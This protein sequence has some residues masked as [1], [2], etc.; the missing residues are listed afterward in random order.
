MTK[1]IGMLSMYMAIIV[2][3]CRS[4]STQANKNNDTREFKLAHHMVDLAGLDESMNYFDF[5]AEK[6]DVDKT[7]EA[8]LDFALPTQMAYFDLDQYDQHYQEEV[9]SADVY[10]EEAKHEPKTKDSYLGEMKVDVG[11]L[12]DYAYYYWLLKSEYFIPVGERCAIPKLNRDENEKVEQEFGQLFLAK[13]PNISSERVAIILRHLNQFNLG[14]KPKRRILS[15][16]MSLNR[17]NVCN[18]AQL[19]RLVKQLHANKHDTNIGKYLGYLSYN[20]SRDCRQ[21][22]LELLGRALRHFD[23]F[24]K[25][26]RVLMRNV[27][28]VLRTYKGV[29]FNQTPILMIVEQVMVSVL[30]NDGNFVHS[31]YKELYITSPDKAMRKFCNNL[32]ENMP[33]YLELYMQKDDWFG[34]MGDPILYTNRAYKVCKLFLDNFKFLE[35]A[36][37]KSFP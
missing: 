24:R 11:E 20:I 7:K 18:G 19:T 23:R 25:S 37:F 31:K 17:L 35:M 10:F 30:R 27:M 29:R 5:E 32:I 2:A 21:F 14:D 26:I 8:D 33:V 34:E 16:V 13:S 6:E 12:G 1:S 36:E 4:A 3:C 28:K 9:R 15:E 22:T